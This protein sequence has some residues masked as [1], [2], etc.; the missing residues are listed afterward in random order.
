MRAGRTNTGK[1][2]HN[3]S[4]IRAAGGCCVL[5]LTQN[6]SART[7]NVNQGMVGRG[8]AAAAA[9]HPRRCCCRQCGR[10]KGGWG[11]EG[12]SATA[13]RLPSLARQFVSGVAG[14]ANQALTV[15]QK[16]RLTRPPR[17]LPPPRRPPP[18]SC[19]ALPPSGA[20]PPAAVPRPWRRAPCAPPPP[21]AARSAGRTGREH[22]R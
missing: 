18:G 6:P 3:P 20:A 15:P 19:A 12:G 16:S 2:D 11:R 8:A 10:L 22:W 1:M 17:P 9:P 14:P 7:G 21:C 5:L 4:G 13:R